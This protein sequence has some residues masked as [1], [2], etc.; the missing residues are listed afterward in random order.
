MSTE[1]YDDLD[2][3]LI[4]ENPTTLDTE[5]K[6]DSENK[7]PSQSQGIDST[8]KSNE[9]D[10]NDPQVQQMMTELQSEFANL[11]KHQENVDGVEGSVDKEAIDNFNNLIGALGKASTAEEETTT[12]SKDYSMKNGIDG[13][14]FKNV[15]A[16]TLD[17]LKESGSNIDSSLKEEKAAE[18]GSD[19]VLSQ[20][21]NQ[22]VD[23]TGEED[24]I[25]FNDDGMDNA[26]LNILTQMSSKEVLY[27]PMKEMKDDFS[28]WF[29]ENETK[30]E[31]QDKMNLY[32]KQYSL[33]Q[34][35]VSLYEREDYDNKLFQNEITNLLDELEQLGDSPVGKGFN[36]SS[37]NE[38]GL[39]DLAKML[40][41]DG[42]D[43]SMGNID[44][45]ITENCQQQ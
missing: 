31:H 33:V 32:K 7:N 15:I 14:D 3:L 38:G 24:G 39:D 43:Q 23:G 2:D 5:T 4:D 35:L 21:L 22:L 17:R 34:E 27:T 18:Q 10:K 29:E 1:E 20:L 37:V 36:N 44:K 40:Q 25:D 13:A 26:I 45:D 12:S 8:L 16:N 28:K 6:L 42:D 41:V 19:D 30:D 11:L 9:S